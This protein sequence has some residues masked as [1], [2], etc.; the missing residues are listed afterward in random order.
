MWRLKWG[1]AHD[2]DGIHEH[3]SARASG[4]RRVVLCRPPAQP[5]PKDSTTRKHADKAEA[6]GCAGGGAGSGTG[7]SN[8]SGGDGDGGEREIASSSDS[9]EDDEDDSEST[10]ES[11]EEEGSDCATKK[12]EGVAGDGSTTGH[13][14]DVS[15]SDGHPPC[16]PSPTVAAG[17]PEI[18]AMPPPSEVDMLVLPIPASPAPE[19]PRIAGGASGGAAGA[20][21]PP[22]QAP[23]IYSPVATP[24]QS[25]AGADGAETR[26]SPDRLRSVRGDD[27]RYDSLIKEASALMFLRMLNCNKPPYAKR[28]VSLHRFDGCVSFF[29]SLGLPCPVR[30]HRCF[31][32]RLQAR[33]HHR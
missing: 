22:E 1:A 25:S 23:S 4:R 16:G 32:R 13:V 8:S 20:S 6:G 9:E 10:D 14:G 2:Q 29:C 12:Q 28:A 5:P 17:A 19:A 21:P 15:G 30:H 18:E 11:D 3:P 31:S 26:A 24:Q 7:G 27:R 33:P